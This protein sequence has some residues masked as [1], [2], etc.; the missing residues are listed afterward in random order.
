MIF[1]VKCLIENSVLEEKLDEETME[2][3]RKELP[4]VLRD[5][6]TS[7]NFHFQINDAYM[8]LDESIKKEK[9]KHSSD[10]LWQ[11][12]FWFFKINLVLILIQEKQKDALTKLDS[13][14]KEIDIIRESMYEIF[15]PEIEVSY[16]FISSS[17]SNIYSY[18]V[19]YWNSD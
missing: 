14:Q 10:F 13:I 1:L 17:L 16:F 19:A 18:F 11:Y 3:V 6:L 4:S 8:K 2:M 9:G 15:R 7:E 5:M 12:Q